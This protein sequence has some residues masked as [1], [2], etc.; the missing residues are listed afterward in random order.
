MRKIAGLLRFQMILTFDFFFPLKFLTNWQ[1]RTFKRLR[2]WR[3]KSCRGGAIG[4]VLASKPWGR[5]FKSRFLIA[6]FF[7]LFSNSTR[8]HN[9]GFYT[10][11]RRGAD[12]EPVYA[13]VST[14]GVQLINAVSR[15]RKFYYPAD[16]Y[17]KSK[18]AQV[19]FTKHLEDLFV[20]N[21]LKIQTHSLH[22]GVVD[23]EL[24]VHSSTDYIPWL[25]RLLFKV[26]EK[27]LKFDFFF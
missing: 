6:S 5:E 20:Q 9:A 15:S 27:D 21:G 4:R 16:A 3:F 10:P 24:F 26:S 11:T 22:P 18:L 23:T 25:R 19:L 17:N 1:K 14:H 8:R 12:T 7:I 13:G 2:R